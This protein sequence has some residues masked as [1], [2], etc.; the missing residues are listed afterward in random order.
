[1]SSGLIIFEKTLPERLAGVF[2]IQLRIRLEYMFRIAGEAFSKETAVFE[3][4][5]SAL[6]ELS[7]RVAI[8]LFVVGVGNLAI[9]Y[10]TP[11]IAT[12]F[13]RNWIDLA[14]ASFTIIIV[15]IVSVRMRRVYTKLVQGVASRLGKRHR[16]ENERIES[17]L[18]L[19]TIALVAT[20]VLL[21]SFPL[22]ART[23]SSVF[24][25]LG[26]G[27]VVVVLIIFFFIIAGRA[28]LR[29]TRQLEETFELK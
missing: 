2:P 24:G 1:M 27:F 11:F 7:R 23:F 29:A 8:I 6:W 3:V 15:L 25:D 20:T 22:I 12:S 17:F 19:M 5:R 26:S 13:I 9:T 18:Y 16:T 10:V 21:V 28:A 4:I 14:I